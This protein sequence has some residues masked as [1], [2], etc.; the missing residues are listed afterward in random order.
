MLGN[1]A[2]LAEGF[3]EVVLDDA[4]D[5]FAPAEGEFFHADDAPAVRK[6]P[7]ERLAAEILLRRRAGERNF[8]LRPFPVG[9]V[10]GVGGFEKFSVP[11]P[12]LHT[13]AKE[14]RARKVGHAHGDAVHPA[15]CNCR[16]SG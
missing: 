7:F 11:F 10:E 8:P 6:F 3:G 16:Y 4:A 15:V 13:E 9:H 5:A 12:E 14:R 1:S 2:D